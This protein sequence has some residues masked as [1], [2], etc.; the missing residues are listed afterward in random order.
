MMKKIKLTSVVL[1]AAIGLSLCACSGGGEGGVG[2]TKF[3]VFNYDG[4]YGTQWL[5][6]AEADYEKTHTDVDIVIQP[7]KTANGNLTPSQIKNSTCK[8]FFMEQVSYSSLIAEGVVGDLTDV[9]TSP[10]P[11]DGNKTVIGKFTDQQKDYYNVSGV[12]YGIPHYAGNNG[13]VYNKDLFDRN[14]WYF[15]REKPT[16]SDVITDDY[17]ITVANQEKSA[18]PNGKTGVIDGVDYSWD[19]GLP[20][21]YEEFIL[22]LDYIKSFNI[23]NLEPLTFSGQSREQYVGLLYNALVTDYEGAEQMLMNYTFE[24]TATDLGSIVDGKFVKDAE[25]TVITEENGYELTR[26]AGRYYALDFLNKILSNTAY[27]DKSNAVK[28]TDSTVD[29]QTRFLRERAAIMVEGV[30]WESE[31]DQAGVFEQLGK[32][33][34]D[35]N[36]AWMPFP[37]ADESKIGTETVTDNIYSLCFIKNDLSEREKEIAKDFIQFLYSDEM[38]SAYTRDTG[39]VKALN[40]TVSDEDLQSLSEYGK[41]VYKHKQTSETIYPFANNR[42]FLNNQADF[43]GRNYY[44]TDYTVGNSGSYKYVTKMLLDDYI[45]G[46]KVMPNVEKYFSGMYTYYT[47]QWSSYLK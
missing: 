27:Y 44:A 28:G 25:S 43:H 4:G 35:Y 46:N 36:F 16:G 15:K 19:D 2:K 39:T 9:L 10:N 18:G 5:K 11:Y 31:S 23:Q 47:N 42:I 26:Q 30:W 14:L 12:Y 45:G 6:N 17:F 37:K 33:K 20:A 7:Q 1:T 34:Y 40:Y 8:L 24:G 38:L 21:T 3:Y 41:S 22:L 29:A 32:T 13:F